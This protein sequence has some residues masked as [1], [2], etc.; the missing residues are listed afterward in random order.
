MSGAKQHILP[1]FLLKGF[2]TIVLKGIQYT[3]WFIEK[4]DKFLNRT[5]KIYAQKDTSME[6]NLILVL[7][8]IL[9]R[10]KENMVCF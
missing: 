10:A 5:S 8:L 6:R 3:H 2:A 9:P 1:K 4:T 7:T